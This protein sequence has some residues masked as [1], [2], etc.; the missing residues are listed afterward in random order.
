MDHIDKPPLD[1]DRAFLRGVTAGLEPVQFSS[2]SGDYRV[3]TLP[4]RI[5]AA[6]S[7]NTPVNPGEIIIYNGVPTA[8]EDLPT[9]NLRALAG[10]GHPEPFHRPVIELPEGIEWAYTPNMCLVASGHRGVWVDNEHLACPG[11]GMDFT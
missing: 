8:I 1:A 3:E 4:A 7:L 5:E 9:A 10:Y 2:P 11:C 6:I